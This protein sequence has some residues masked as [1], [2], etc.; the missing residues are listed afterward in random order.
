MSLFLSPSSIILS[1]PFLSSTRHLFFPSCPFSPVCLSLFL[2]SLQSHKIWSQSSIYSACGSVAMTTKL[3]ARELFLEQC[4]NVRHSLLSLF[5]PPSPS[6]PLSYWMCVWLGI[7]WWSLW[8]VRLATWSVNIQRNRKASERRRA[9][10]RA[11]RDLFPFLRKRR[12]HF[13][14]FLTWCFGDLWSFRFLVQ[15]QTPIS[16]SCRTQSNV[17]K[18]KCLL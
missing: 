6:L 2:A 5:F 18:V 4:C 12:G 16:G 10:R 1:F 11:V 3:E 7:G 17:F 15:T 9:A 8:F 14:I 13:Q